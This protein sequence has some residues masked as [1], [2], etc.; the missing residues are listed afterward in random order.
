MRETARHL[1]RLG[2]P[3]DVFTRS[4]DPSVPQVVALGEGARVIH[5]EAGPRHP[6]SPAAMAAHLD[7]FAEGVESFRLRS[8]ADYALLHAHYWL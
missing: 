8:G 5:V 6:M 7:A 3:V 1:G 2:L 4:Q